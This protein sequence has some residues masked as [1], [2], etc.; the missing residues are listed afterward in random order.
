MFIIYLKK[1]SLER[2]ILSW[3]PDSL[4]LAWIPSVKW[5]HES[6]KI[7]QK[8]VVSNIIWL[9]PDS[10]MS[11]LTS[12]SWLNQVVSWHKKWIKKRKNRKKERNRQVKKQTNKQ[13][14]VSG[15]SKLPF[16][17]RIKSTL[18]WGLFSGCD[19]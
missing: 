1:S 15:M 4:M 5:W 8:V 13:T 7:P 11:L 14:K 12:R 19:D 6:C 9:V 16:T 17:C 10:I 3:D 2:R 18:M